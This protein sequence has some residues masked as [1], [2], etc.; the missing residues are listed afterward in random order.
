MEKKRPKR[1]KDKDNPYTLYCCD[2]RY[3][4]MFENGIGESYCIEIDQELFRLFDMFELEDKK[5]MNY[6]DRHIEHAEL[7]ER[8]VYLKGERCEI[9][10]EDKAISM[11]QIQE[12]RDAIGQLPMVQ[13]R[14]LILRYFYDFTYMEIANIE[15]CSVS[16]VVR[17]IKAAENK[18]KKVIG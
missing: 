10:A 16:S 13:R 6:Y 3:F 17:A 1:R 18:L 2:Y 15:K 11:M 14:R 4:I 12:L 9:S 7:S 8:T 5:Q